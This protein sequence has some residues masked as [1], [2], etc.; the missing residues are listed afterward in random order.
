[1][2]SNYFSYNTGKY[3][4]SAARVMGWII[5][6]FGVLTLLN[7]SYTAWLLLPVGILMHFTHYRA[8][9]DLQ[10][11]RYREGV[12]IGKLTVGK[13]IPF[14]GFGFLFLKHNKYRQTL[15]SRGSMSTFK[16][17]K[18]DGYLKLADGTNLHLLQLKNKQDAMAKMDAISRDLDVEFRDLTDMKYY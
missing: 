5:T 2:D 11:M 18:Y 16:M 15:E 13:M 14:N 17:E 10:H 6:I 7:G 4:S 12:G 3:F 8:E 1:M 9:F